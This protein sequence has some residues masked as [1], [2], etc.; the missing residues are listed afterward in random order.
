MCYANVSSLH[1]Q[2]LTKSNHIPMA[3]YLPRF[4]SC[5]RFCIRTYLND[6]AVNI[7]RY[8][9]SHDLPLQIDDISLLSMTFQ[10]TRLFGLAFIPF[11]NI[12][13]ERS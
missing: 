3:Q 7:F 12:L 11:Q 6:P 2:S 4:L 10:I 1:D 13:L 9:C 8:E 5:N